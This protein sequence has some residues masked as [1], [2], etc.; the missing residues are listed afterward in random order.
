MSS[1]KDHVGRGEAYC[2]AIVHC[3]ITF[4]GGL[5]PFFWWLSPYHPGIAVDWCHRF[6]EQFRLTSTVLFN[7]IMVLFRRQNSTFFARE[8]Y[9]ACNRDRCYWSYKYFGG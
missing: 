5:Y 8:K 2:F 6:I 3:C 9:N 7:R 4:L 1:S